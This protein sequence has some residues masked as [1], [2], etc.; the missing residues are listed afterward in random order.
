MSCEDQAL[1]AT[2]RCTQ[3]RTGF[4]KGGAPVYPR[5]RKNSS[6]FWCCPICGCSYGTEPH[7]DL[8]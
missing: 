7:P 8:K 3:C 4:T 6:G 1:F 2:K 5:L